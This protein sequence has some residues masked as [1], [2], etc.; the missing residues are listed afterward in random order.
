MNRASYRILPLWQKSDT[1][2]EA[3]SKRAL[4]CLCALGMASILC[5]LTGIVYLLR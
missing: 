1:P 2:A 4:A 3:L 5:G